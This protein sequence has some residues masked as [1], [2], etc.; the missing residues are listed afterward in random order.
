ML[1]GQLTSKLRKAGL[2][3]IAATVQPHLALD[4]AQFA[5]HEDVGV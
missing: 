3:V 4:R 2:R 1:K 5:K